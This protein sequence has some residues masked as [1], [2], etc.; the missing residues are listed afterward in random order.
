MSKA[1]G[2]E[3]RFSKEGAT[4]F[5]FNIRFRREYHALLKDRMRMCGILCRGSSFVITGNV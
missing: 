4:C 1:A 2:R 3:E 5:R